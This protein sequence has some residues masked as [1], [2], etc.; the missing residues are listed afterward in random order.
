MK[1][2]LLDKVEQTWVV[3]EENRLHHSFLCPRIRPKA[4]ITPLRRKYG[5]TSDALKSLREN[6]QDKKITWCVGCCADVPVFQVSCVEVEENR[7]KKVGIHGMSVPLDVK[8]VVA[9]LNNAHYR[10]C[11]LVEEGGALYRA[12]VN[13]DAKSFLSTNPDVITGNN[14]LA[15]GPC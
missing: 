6:N 13:P 15:T 9:S 5:G 14:L 3:D 11:T 12:E 2:Y 1:E 7:I 10:L 8:V 4:S